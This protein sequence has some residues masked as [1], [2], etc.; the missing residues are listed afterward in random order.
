[1]LRKATGIAGAIAAGALLTT[2]LVSADFNSGAKDGVSTAPTQRAQIN[3]GNKSDALPKVANGDAQKRI[4]A[5]EVVGVEDTAIVY[6]D[7][8]G[9][10]LFKTDPVSNVTVVT[11]G[12]VLP[13]VTIRELAGSAVQVLPLEGI[14][15]ILSPTA[16]GDG[17]ESSVTAHTAGEA[18]A[19]VPS[20]CITELPSST[21]IA[22]VN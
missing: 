11:K 7:R 10:I 13:E 8:D 14:R 21:N 16:P 20:R 19:R 4:T 6:R 1:M 3:R 22:A 17:C 12:V 2:A 15:P 5:I 18:L 9:N